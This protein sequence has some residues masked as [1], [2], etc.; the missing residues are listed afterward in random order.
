MANLVSDDSHVK[1]EPFFS[2]REG[3]WY[4]VGWT[5][6]D[7]Y[8]QV[9]RLG[10]RALELLED[11]LSVRE[12]QERLVAE[13]KTAA[14]VVGFVQNLARRG[15]VASIDGQV[16]RDPAAPVPSASRG[17]ALLTNFDPRLVRWLF[18][19][20]M[21]GLYGLLAL[22]SGLVLVARPDL[23]P[24]SG[25]WFFLSFYGL[26]IFF[27]FLTN[28]ALVMVHELGHLAAA[29]AF[30]IGGR[31]SI[32]RRLYEPVAV[33]KLASMWRLPKQQRSI[34]NL[35]GIFVNVCLFSIVLFLL[36]LEPSWLPRLVH[37][38]L[39]AALVTLWVSSGWQLSLYQRTDIYYLVADLLGT[40]NL[41]DDARRFI[42][43]ILARLVPLV[44]PAADGWTLPSR[45]ARKVQFYSVVY[46]LGIG[47]ASYFFFFY[48]LPFL[49]RTIVG[50]L[51]V[52]LAGTASGFRFVDSLLVL[53]VLGTHY[54][55]L[56]AVWLSEQ[57]HQLLA[58]MRGA[59]SQAA[60]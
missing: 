42:R 7:V 52:V 15:L 18:S 59:R 37:S 10:I 57:N 31:L 38:W 23:V 34:V 12:A 35:A 20:P 16:I 48:N 56:V 58:I 41:M 6:Q 32:S 22:S 36:A 43:H 11:G 29:R 51:G 25:D 9:P 19:T 4:L 40:R 13:E 47:V 14:N 2:R 30:G 45:E 50:A 28:I 8:L 24:T 46:V 39:Q 44:R 26:N 53:L 17:I 27:V 55:I 60:R 1:F 49:F 33:T 54:G 3:E 5:K 21:L